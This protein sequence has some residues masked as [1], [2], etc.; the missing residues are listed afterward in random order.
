V[1]AVWLSAILLGAL[2]ALIVLISRRRIPESPRWL[3]CRGRHAEA[4]R[5]AAGLEAAS[6]GRGR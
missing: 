1:L 3:A 6:R 5:I 2:L 4:D